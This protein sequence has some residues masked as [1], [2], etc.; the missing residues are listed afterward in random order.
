MN[1]TDHGVTQDGGGL[2]QLVLG[3]S[4][5]EQDGLEQAGVVQVNVIVPFLQS[6]KHAFNPPCCNYSNKKKKK[7]PRALLFNGRLAE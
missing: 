7:N 6:Q 2:A 3:D 1:C 4:A 5:V